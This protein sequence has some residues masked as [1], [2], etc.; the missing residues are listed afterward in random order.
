MDEKINLVRSIFNSDGFRNGSEQQKVAI[1]SQILQTGELSGKEVFRIYNESRISNNTSNNTLNIPNEL[2]ASQATQLA[3]LPYDVFINVILAGDIRGEDLLSLCNSSKVLQDYCNRSLTL[4]NGQE[5]SQYLFRQ[6]IEKTRPGYVVNDNDVPKNVYE[7]LTS[8]TPE[9]FPALVGFLEQLQDH[10]LL[11][12]DEYLPAPRNIQT[13]L[14]N[15]QDQWGLLFRNLKL[16]QRNPAIGG[17]LKIKKFLDSSFDLLNSNLQYIAVPE[18]I[19]TV[20]QTILPDNNMNGAQLIAVHNIPMLPGGLLPGMLPAANAINPILALQQGQ[21]HPTLNNLV[22]DI[23]HSVI[24]GVYQLWEQTHNFPRILDYLKDTLNLDL[25]TIVAR[26]YQAVSMTTNPAFSP[27]SGL[28][29]AHIVNLWQNYEQ[30]YRNVINDLLPQDTKELNKLIYNSLVQLVDRYLDLYQNSIN[31]LT[32]QGM[33][34]PSDALS[35][36]A[37][38]TQI[39]QD[40]HEGVYNRIIKWLVNIHKGVLSGQYSLFTPISGPPQ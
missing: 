31:E 6:L 20:N 7:R 26:T 2:D 3:K 18:N 36:L 10:E 15:D 37:E 39:S 35:T 34:L 25:E 13:L 16:D 27:F 24:G 14:Y 17:A 28:T 30:S 1:I 4:P 8:K 12:D 32:A 9:D 33:E 21:F 22:P 23:F 40:L 29:E 38:L 11:P 19:P 5:V